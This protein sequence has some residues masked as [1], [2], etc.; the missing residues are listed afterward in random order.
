MRPTRHAALLC[1]VLLGGC[2]GA[3]APTQPPSLPASLQGGAAIPGRVAIANTAQVFGQPAS[4]AGQPVRAANAISQLEWLTVDILTSQNFVNL[5]PTVPGALRQARDAV[6]Q[7][8][9]VVPD[10]TPQAAVNAFDGAA[11]ALA[12]GDRAAAQASLATVTG[13]AGA[14]RA[15]DLLS[16]LPSIPAAASGTA[17]AVNGLATMDQ[18]NFR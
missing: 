10:T 11:S 6:R 17:I 9:G 15:L 7:A 13:P 2:T 16:A 18:R 14:P 1:L 3:M 4:V 8:F 5:P 12:G